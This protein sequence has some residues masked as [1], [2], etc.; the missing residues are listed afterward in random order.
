MPGPVIIVVAAAYG[1][2]ALVMFGAIGTSITY[3]VYTVGK[4]IHRYVITAERR[5][6]AENAESLQREEEKLIAR[7]SAAESIAARVQQQAAVF[8]ENLRVLQ[9]E[10]NSAAEHLHDA[11]HEITQASTVLVTVSTANR[12]VQTALPDLLQSTEALIEKALDIPSNLASMTQSLID[13][14]KRLMEISAELQNLQCLTEVQARTFDE[15]H[16]EVASLTLLNQGQRDEISQLREHNE[17][18]LE[19]IELLT[20]EMAALLDDEKTADHRCQTPTHRFF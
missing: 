2:S 13:K 4:K 9:V 20:G 12:D 18:L 1:P 5:S 3:G 7:Q 10:E 17:I 14:E 11:T 8:A 16:K 19:K 15:I 6:S